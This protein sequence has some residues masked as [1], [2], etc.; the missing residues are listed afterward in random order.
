MFS[1]MGHYFPN[2]FQY[3]LI[4]FRYFPNMFRYFPIFSEPPNPQ[5][6]PLKKP[7]S[8]TSSL[9]LARAVR[10]FPG[11]ASSGSGSLG[12]S[13]GRAQWRRLRIP[14]GGPRQGLGTTASVSELV[15]RRA[16]ASSLPR[17]GV[18]AV[19]SVYCFFFFDVWGSGFFLVFLVSLFFL[20]FFH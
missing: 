20:S 10:H 11:L 8:P 17:Q 2:I 16:L 13:G 1:N 7:K 14:T 4:M 19:F 15:A 6:L 18:F 5:N 3:F 12:A 9:T